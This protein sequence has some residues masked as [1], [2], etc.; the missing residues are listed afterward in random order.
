MSRQLF[1]LRHLISRCAPLQLKKVPRAL[2]PVY[3]HCHSKYLHVERKEFKKMDRGEFEEV[4]EKTF[5]ELIEIN[6]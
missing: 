2:L 3:Y 4:R 1:L 5:K 6:V